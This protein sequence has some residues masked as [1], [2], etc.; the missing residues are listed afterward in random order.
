MSFS[1]SLATKCIYF[2]DEPCMARPTLIDLN[3]VEVNYYPFMISLGKFYG[4]CN[5]VDDLS[6]KMCVQSETK[7]VNGKG[8]NLIT[9]MNE[10]KTL[11]KH[12]SCDC[13]CKFNSTACKSNQKWNN[14]KCQQ[15]K[16]LH[17]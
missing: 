2:S 8:F 10:V 11:V 16:V 3:A 9:T 4:S 5:A 6:T 14:D 7:A 15:E 13:E 1:R 12:I 17:V